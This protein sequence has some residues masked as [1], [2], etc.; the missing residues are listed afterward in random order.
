[1]VLIDI[2][3]VR[4]DVTGLIDLV[5]LPAVLRQTG[6]ELSPAQVLGRYLDATAALGGRW[7]AGA[8]RAA[9]RA[10]AAATGLE[11]LHGLDR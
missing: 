4:P 11:D 10:Y 6:H 5:T 9:L 7:T 8:L 1:V 2:E 3:T